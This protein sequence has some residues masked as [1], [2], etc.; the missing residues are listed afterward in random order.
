M[1]TWKLIEYARR[2]G[3]AQESM[4]TTQN[5]A[6]TGADAL[7]K[8]NDSGD[9]QHEVPGKVKRLRVA[10]HHP[11]KRLGQQGGKALNF[12]DVHVVLVTYVDRGFH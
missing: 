5:E 3:A 2:A 7:T 11:R 9:S 12:V 6:G 10:R 4:P 8:P 1:V